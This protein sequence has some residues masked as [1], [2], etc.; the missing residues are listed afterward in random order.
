MTTLTP[1]KTSFAALMRLAGPIFVAN[2]AIVGSGTID[3][4]MAGQLGKNHLAAIA[5]SKMCIRDRP[6]VHHPFRRSDA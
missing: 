5:V 1:P 2:I 6:D 4:I 3:T